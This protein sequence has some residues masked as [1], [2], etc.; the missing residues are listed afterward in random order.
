MRH[1]MTTWS[2]SLTAV[3]LAGCALGLPS[4]VDRNW[5]SA[6]RDNTMAMIVNPQ[7]SPLDHD[8]GAKQDGATVDDA[9][10]AYRKEQKQRKQPAATP[11]VIN[12]GT[13]GR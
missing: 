12:I 7:G 1:R 2:I 6:Q 9:I 8:P 3:L 13:V 5:G 4:R 10:G 11:S